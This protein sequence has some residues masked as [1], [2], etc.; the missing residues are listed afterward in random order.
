MYLF[1]CSLNSDSCARG[2]EPV[3]FQ[4]TAKDVEIPFTYSVKFKKNNDVR[5]AS[6]WDYIHYFKILHVIIKW[7]KL[8]AK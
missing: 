1:N 3:L 8:L 5:W 2:V 4:S 6:R 7:L